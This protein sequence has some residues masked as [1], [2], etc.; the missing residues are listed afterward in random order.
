MAPVRI[1][2][3]VL[4]WR[5][6]EATVACL[7][8]LLA[9][10]F[11][12]LHAI[13]I[14]NGSADGSAERIAAAFPQ[15]ELLRNQ[16]NLGYCAAMNHGMR[17]ARELGAEFVLF[18]NNDVILRAG[19]LAALLDALESDPSAAAA[20][21]KM[22]LPDGRLWCAGGILRFGPNLS[23]LR[24]HHQRDAGQFEYPVPVDYMP[25]ACCLYRVAD[26]AAVGDLDEDYF[27]YV[28]DVDLGRRLA[29]LGRRVLYIPWA[30]VEH[31]ASR[32]TGGGRSPVRKYMN[33]VNSVRFLRRH[34][35][36][37]DWLGFVLCDLLAWPL[38]LLVTVVRLRSPRPVWA[39]GRGLVRGLL[40]HRL[41]ASD[42][43]SGPS[44]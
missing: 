29:A 32:S 3:L 4:N 28:E 21:P 16:S 1:A 19:C 12:G 34:G 17:R 13:A 22:V 37:R 36:V 24:G 5:Q 10:S 26:M 30:V 39:K 38:L 14:D 43:R 42:V 31:D 35:R 41:T 9:E 6:A 11:P 44:P 20:G 2:A 40:G 25:G 7:Q 23:V 15:L 33:A 27:M 18:L 8:S